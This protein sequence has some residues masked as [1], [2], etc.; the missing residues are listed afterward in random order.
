MSSSA[1]FA[2]PDLRAFHLRETAGPPIPTLAKRRRQGMPQLSAEA[3]E[4]SAVESMSALP[5]G[6]LR[7]FSI[8]VETNPADGDRIFK[9]GASSDSLNQSYSNGTM[10]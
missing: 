5:L 3:Q 10:I 9:L 6:W 2:A 7:A 1:T 8:D 4:L